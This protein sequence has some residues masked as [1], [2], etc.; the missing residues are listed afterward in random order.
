MTNLQPG[1]RFAAARTVSEAPTARLPAEEGGAPPAP[2]GVAGAAGGAVAARPPAAAH[3]GE[4]AIFA[5]LRASRGQ[6]IP[7]EVAERAR[8]ITADCADDAARARALYDWI[9]ANI[10]YDVQEWAHITGGGDAYTNDHDPASVLERGSTVCAGYAWL[11]NAMAESVGLKATFL[12]GD[13]RGY[14]G[15]ADEK[16]ISA[17]KHAWNAVQI[18]GEWRLID[19]TWGARQN[20]EAADGYLARRDYYFDT[21]PRQMIFDHLPE[22]TSWQLLSHPVPDAAAFR[23]LPNLKPAFFRDG[24]RLGNAFAATLDAPTAARGSLILDAPVTTSVVATLSPLANANDARRLPVLR[25]ETRRDIVV[26]P[27]APGSYLLRVYSRAEEDAGPYECAADFVVQ[28][29]G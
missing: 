21:P 24:L 17:F 11:F 10:R 9:T 8:S 28:T 4:P 5:A 3:P 7:V 2:A 27:L 13:V 19:A 18:D 14:R 1:V 20:G 29:G 22:E 6:P 15:T 26:G 16:L 23:A 25:H 12:I